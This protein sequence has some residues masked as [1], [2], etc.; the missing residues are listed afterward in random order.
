MKSPAWTRAAAAAVT[1]IATAAPSAARSATYHTITVDG[2]RADFS[3]DEALAGDPLGDSTYAEN[4]DLSALSVTWDAERLYL[5][6]DYRAE[7]TAVM[8]FVESGAA[9]GISDLCTS[10]VFPANLQGPG[11][12]LLVAFFAPS[13]HGAAPAPYVYALS[14]A[15]AV[16]ITGQPG[17]EVQLAESVSALGRD[18]SL[19]A[20]VPWDLLYGLGAGAVPP[21][22]TLRVAAAIRGSL[23][24]DNVGDVSPDPSTPLQQSECGAGPAT[25]LDLFHLVVV[26]PG[27]DG[28]P[29][30][31][32][33]PGL[34]P[35]DAGASP[36][37][38]A[39]G[40]T[41]AA[42]ED[43]GAVTE[44]A[45]VPDAGPALD[46]PSADGISAEGPRPA[47]DAQRADGDPS[48]DA[49]PSTVVQE[50]GCGCAAPGPG[51]ALPAGLVTALLAG[52]GPA[53]RRRR[54]GR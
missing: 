1:V 14:S 2:D 42:A 47:G 22:A 21:G 30:D 10:A 31:G 51:P 4:N 40:D 39:G 19:E 16:D 43:A 29:E 15:G 32:W 8:L 26:D 11:L 28:I 7:N 23:D 44:D 33:S 9:G 46:L 37:T 3:A 45:G 12:D 25:V 48:R 27:G 17:V 18:G 52:L 41:G 20:A 5:G 6:V 49:G 36:D 38:S 34:A 13:D 53:V 24:G 54:R 50:E 35:A